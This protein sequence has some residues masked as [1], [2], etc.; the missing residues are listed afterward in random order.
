[1][2]QQSETIELPWTIHKL[3]KWTDSYFKSRNIENP[4]A[5]AEIILAHALGLKRIDLYIQYDQPLVDKEL[6]LF[7]SLIKRRINKEPVAYIVGKK[8]F[9]SMNLE[10]TRDVLIPRPETECLIEAALKFLP[11]DSKLH[12]KK[13]LEL[14]TGTGAI[15]IALASERP[16][17]MYFASDWSQKAL[18]VAKRNAK[19]HILTGE[20]SFICGDWFGPFKENSIFFD[21]LLSNPPYIKTDIIPDLEP[22]IKDYEPFGALDGDKDGLGAIRH[23]LYSACSYLADKG[24]ML[25]EIGH[26]QKEDVL[27]IVESCGTYENFCCLKDYSGN[28]R[29]VQIQKKA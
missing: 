24:W 15:T 9:W 14:G 2:Q 28:N 11:D 23:I 27:K 26:D 4:R 29:V 1:M 25:L 22:E 3:L 20:V 6:A 5:S 10:V 8:E 13:I 21:M 12:K 7:K 18:A 19:Q 17:N 16:F